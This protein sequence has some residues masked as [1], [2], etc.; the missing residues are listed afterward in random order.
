[1]LGQRGL[2]HTRTDPRGLTSVL[3]D[4]QFDM[5]LLAFNDPNVVP[6]LEGILTHLRSEDN[7]VRGEA[8]ALLMSDWQAT[9]P[10]QLL[11][12]LSVLMKD[13]GD[14][15]LRAFAAIL[16]RRLGL[17]QAGDVEG[18]TLWVFVGE[19]CRAFCQN[20]LLQAVS[21]EAEDMVRPKLCDSIADLARESLVKQLPW[22]ELLNFVLQGMN[23]DNAVIRTAV[24]HVVAGLPSLVD[25]VPL[26]D[27][28]ASLRTT[29]S[30]PNEEMKVQALHASVNY[31]LE[32]LIPDDMTEVS[33]AVRNGLMELVP[34][35]LNVVASFAESNEEKLVEGLSSLVELAEQDSRMFRQLLPQMIEFLTNV[36]RNGNFDATARH[37]ALELLLTIAENRPPMVRKHAQFCNV[38]VP[39][40]LEWMSS[41]VDSESWHTVEDL[42]N[43]D[44]DNEDDYIIAEQGMD[45]LS[46]ALGGKSI[47]PVAFNLIP[48][49][50]GDE[51]WAKRHAGLMAISVMGEGCNDLMKESLRDFV[52]LI[53]PYLRDAHPRVRYAACNA[54]GQ[55][56]TDFAPDMQNKYCDAML[57]G[58][59]PVMEDTANPR[60]QAHCA[61][62]LVNLAEDVR[63]DQI[64]PFLD[65]MFSRLVK[66]L[67]SN[68]MY[69]QEQAITTI[70]TIADS[71]EEH[72]VK[73]YND[74]MPIL[75]TL[76][77]GATDK[78]F[79]LLRGKSLEC[80]SLIAL[81]VGKETFAAHAEGFINLLIQ[82]QNTERE[83]DDPITSYL[84]VAWARICK[85]IGG[86]FVPYLDVVMPPLLASASVKPP[87]ALID[88][89]EGTEDYPEEEGWEFIQVDGQRFGIKTNE[90]EDKHTAVEMLACY[91]RDLKGMFIP[92]VERVME[93]VVGL[94]KFYFHEGV[95]HAAASTIPLLFVC[96]HDAGVAKEAFANFWNPVADKMLELMIQDTDTEFSASLFSAYAEC[97]E[98]VG[99]ELISAHQMDLFVTAVQSQ[100]NR[101]NERIQERDASR[102]DADYDEEEEAAIKTDEESDETLLI[103]M[104]RAIHELFKVFGVNFLP[105]FDQLL[106][107]IKAFNNHPVS[108]AR[109]FAICIYGDLIDFGGPASWR[110]HGDFADT[111]GKG[112]VDR[113]EDIRQ[114]TSYAIGLAAEKGGPEYAPLCAQSIP[115]LSQIIKAPK[116]KDDA[117]VLATENCISALGKIC[118]FMGESGL[119][120]FNATLGMF[121][122]A[123]PILNDQEEADHT[124]RYLLSLMKANHPVVLGENNRNIQH[125]IV[126][127][128]DVVS[129][130][131]ELKEDLKMEIGASLQSILASIPADAKLAVWNSFT[132]EKRDAL[133]KLG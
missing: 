19:E 36:M 11:A 89:D 68:K 2:L 96:M 54:V 49:M 15:H 121:V 95:R 9:R 44:D 4:P 33:P 18:I 122:E 24:L 10:Q 127:F 39:L 129:G 126:I 14:K 25:K 31:M 17:K 60:V 108:Y 132:P 71:S 13:H 20:Q 76:L 104:N 85:V 133:K 30:L 77:H 74:I 113:S 128:T 112:L 48:K 114:A 88:S 8:E 103:E 52:T 51:N 29:L 102:R 81:A 63:K 35:M 46:L 45:R 21:N 50:L 32:K 61:A 99:G 73:Y 7:N 64:A 87:V 91:A 38:L 43:D 110:Y 125:L 78:R 28:V 62:A 79:R 131:L 80:A 111:L 86:D 23:A 97:V 118:H 123:L 116:S 70:A 42:A 37:S 119:F 55:M 27:V 105:Y 26:S 124:Y 109:H 3:P 53:L 117:N 16:L 1:M 115:Y 100:L 66:L 47:L 59:L 98:A 5:A 69:V 6:Q 22:P 57:T 82:I 92:W 41:I 106:P 84:L 40:L 130:D 67:N 58:L 90:L 94:L 12:G 56:C 107:G 75:L 65:E 93:C 101:F 83:P 72:F 34:M 120:D